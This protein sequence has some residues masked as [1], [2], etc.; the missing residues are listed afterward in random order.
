MECRYDFH[1]L[2][3]LWNHLNLPGEFTMDIV[4]RRVDACYPDRVKDI[5]EL[6]AEPSV[7][8]RPMLDVIAMKRKRVA[9]LE[10]ISPKDP[11]LE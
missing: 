8:R 5:N 7:Y 10:F 11:R 4:K 6:E 9:E 3:V 1:F 2:T